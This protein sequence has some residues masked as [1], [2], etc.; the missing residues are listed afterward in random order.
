MITIPASAENI[1][2]ISEQEIYHLLQE[3]T[4]NK[5]LKKIFIIMWIFITFFILLFLTLGVCYES[6]HCENKIMFIF[7]IAE[8]SIL[9]M[10]LCS[11]ICVKIIVNK[12]NQLESEL[13]Q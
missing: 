10:I 13:Q 9:F 7:L 11:C 6:I 8:G 12:R 4:Y 3:N 1:D 2:E 5:L